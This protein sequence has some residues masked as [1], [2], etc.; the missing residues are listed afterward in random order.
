MSSN[1]FSGRRQSIHGIFFISSFISIAVTIYFYIWLTTFEGFQVIRFRCYKLKFCSS[2]SQILENRDL[3][4]LPSIAS[5]LDPFYLFLPVQSSS[6][7]IYQLKVDSKDYQSIVNQL[8]A[9]FTVQFRNTPSPKIPGELSYDGKVYK[10]DIN[11]RG[12]GA[13]H[14][15]EQKKS[16]R[17]SIK[18]GETL[19]GLDQVDLVIPSE[20]NYYGFFLNKWTADYLGLHTN[21]LSLVHVYLNNRDYGPFVQLDRW[22]QSFLERR[23]LP[24]GLIFGDIDPSPDRPP[25]YQSPQSWKIYDSPPNTPSDFSAIEKLLTALNHPNLQTSFS[26]L[27]QIIDMDNFVRWE[28][29]AIFFNTRH[30]DDFHNIRLFL[31]PVSGKL[32]FMPIDFGPQLV[33]NHPSDK[34]LL[35]IDYNPLVSRLLQD[36]EI[37]QTRNQVLFDL[38]NDQEFQNKLWQ[39]YDELYSK[40]RGDFYRDPLNPES[41]LRFTWVIHQLK[42]QTQENIIA[43]K[44]LLSQ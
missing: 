21:E 37:Y 10:V 2:L 15:S 29:L 41:N 1:E 25:L 19:G 4:H 27:K 9:P 33:N 11:F 44:K 8:P 5:I 3:S 28:A 14:W 12:I 24:N 13:P 23:G 42:S 7:P 18:S 32:V 36:P 38:I 31:N 30:Q 40:T 16:L 35:N 34:T 6:L 20:S 39:Q 43:L 22:N 26:Q 17:L